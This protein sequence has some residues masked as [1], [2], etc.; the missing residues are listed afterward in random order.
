MKNTGITASKDWIDS[1]KLNSFFIL[2]RVPSIWDTFT[3]L[4]D[5]IYDGSNGDDACKSYEFYQKDVDALKNM[6]VSD[7]FLILHWLLVT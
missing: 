4:N 1:V 6:G 3:R 5:T 7:Q 2:G